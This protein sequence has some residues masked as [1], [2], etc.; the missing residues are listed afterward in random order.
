MVMITSLPTEL[1]HLILIIDGLELVNRHV[2]STDSSPCLTVQERLFPYIRHV[3]LDRR[4]LRKTIARRITE[5]LWPPSVTLDEWIDILSNQGAT[6]DL[7]L[8][9]LEN[10]DLGN[11]SIVPPNVQVAFANS[12]EWGLT[13]TM[14]GDRVSLR[15]DWIYIK[16]DKQ[17]GKTWDIVYRETEQ[18]GKTTACSINESANHFLSVL[19]DIRTLAVDLDRTEFLPIF[20]SSR[21]VIES[22]GPFTKY[23]GEVLHESAFTP[24]ARVLFEAVGTC[25]VF[26]GMGSWTDYVV[27]EPGLESR[28]DEVSARFLNAV[29]QAVLSAINVGRSES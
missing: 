15:P 11:G 28:F 18:S 8:F 3:S 5:K 14:S 16:S 4:V 2:T 20:D 21:E 26:G 19:D 25:W 27:T 23:A 13:I 9:D 6:A 24:G 29:L 12:G 17:D 1:V 10:V 7:A 22:G